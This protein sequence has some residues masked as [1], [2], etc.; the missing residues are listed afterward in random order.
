MKRINLFFVCCKNADKINLCLTEKRNYEKQKV[1]VVD[2][3]K[4]FCLSQINKTLNFN[5]S[6]WIGKKFKDLEEIL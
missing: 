2:F 5:L 6:T 4:D 1:P 3:K